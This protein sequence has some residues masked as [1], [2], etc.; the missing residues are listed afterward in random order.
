MF[1]LNYRMKQTTMQNN[2]IKKISLFAMIALYLLAGINHFIHPATYYALIPP[3]FPFPE[4][5]NIFSGVIEIS[6]AVLLIFLPTRKLAALI[7]I[8]MLIAFIPAHIYM[9]QK[10]GCMSVD[11]CVPV[12]IAWVRLFPLQFILMY[13]AWTNRK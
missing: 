11:F 10:S 3:Y 13:W 2:V 12:W 5:I 9:I 4:L 1:I 8:A 6:V 7:I